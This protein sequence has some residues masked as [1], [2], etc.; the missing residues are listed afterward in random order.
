MSDSKSFVAKKDNFLLRFDFVSSVT[1]D[2]TAKTKMER[3]I[4]SDHD[5]KFQIAFQLF[6]N[7][8]CFESSMSADDDTA[9]TKNE[10][11]KQTVI[12]TNCRLPSS[13]AF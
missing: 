10:S 13:W 12:M 11:L 1:D 6:S 2:D 4:S 5:G 7:L 9:A 3:K 8:C